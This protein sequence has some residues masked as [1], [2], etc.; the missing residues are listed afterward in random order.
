[1]LLAQIL[2]KG[3]NE[4]TVQHV[5]L[6]FDLQYLSQNFVELRGIVQKTV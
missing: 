1:M 3:Q 4:G 2:G 6:L 5:F